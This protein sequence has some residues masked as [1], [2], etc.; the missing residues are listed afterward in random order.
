MPSHRCYSRTL[1]LSVPL[2]S[3]LFPHIASPR[4]HTI[5]SISPDSPAETKR[6]ISQR[7]HTNTLAYHTF[8]MSRMGTHQTFLEGS[9]EH[10]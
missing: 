10:N 2:I 6:H 9:R 3:P 1:V 8:T 4:K 5:A 7:W